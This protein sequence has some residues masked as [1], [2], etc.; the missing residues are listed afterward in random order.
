MKK[1]TTAWWK[2]RSAKFSPAPSANFGPRDVAWSID[3]GTDAISRV[4]GINTVLID[5][6]RRFLRM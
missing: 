6:Y 5:L 1:P 4:V 3:P 2:K